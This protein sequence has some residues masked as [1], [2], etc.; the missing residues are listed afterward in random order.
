MAVVL[1]TTAQARNCQ[2]LPTNSLKLSP[3]V[4]LP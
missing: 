3:S 2:Q 4:S 1:K